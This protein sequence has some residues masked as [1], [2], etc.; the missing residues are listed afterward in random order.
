M[1]SWDGET[2]ERVRCPCGQTVWKKDTSGD[3]DV[4]L[5]FLK[6]M[7]GR[8][9]PWMRVEHTFEVHPFNF[10]EITRTQSVARF[11]LKQA[12]QGRV[13]VDLHETPLII[14]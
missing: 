14:N 5:S 8:L 3:R 1:E 10:V 7:K 13:S 11:C 12:F 6:F 2:E 4:P 9:F